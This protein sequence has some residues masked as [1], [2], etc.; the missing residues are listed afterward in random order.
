M[1]PWLKWL[2]GG[3]LIALLAGA[4]MVWY[5]FTLK[6]SDTSGLKPDYSLPARELLKEFQYNDSLANRKYAEKIILVRGVVTEIEAAD[7]TVN[8]KMADTLSGAY[9]I[10]SF[11][12]QYLPEARKIKEG[13]SIA[14]KGS[15][16]GGA[17]SQILE[18]E[19]ISFKRSTVSNY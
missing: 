9:I 5:F 16:S 1:R 10:F 2:L 15:C 3:L 7:T 18:A 6:F 4:G 13:D 19:Y 12:Q 17:Y 14:I 11:Q 8:I